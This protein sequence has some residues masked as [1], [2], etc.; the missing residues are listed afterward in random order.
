MEQTGY[1]NQIQIIF[2]KIIVVTSPNGTYE[3]LINLVVS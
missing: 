1:K 3:Y 2:V